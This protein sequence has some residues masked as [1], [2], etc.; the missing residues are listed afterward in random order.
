MPRPHPKPPADDR[1]EDCAPA[2]FA[3]MCLAIER[4][5]FERATEARRELKRLG[6]SVMQTKPS[7]RKG[8]V[9]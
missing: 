5:N 6:W 4:G 1:P 8:G 9:A 3:A 7:T 2:W